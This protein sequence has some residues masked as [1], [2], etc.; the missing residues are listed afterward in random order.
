MTEGKREQGVAVVVWW[1][2]L[3]TTRLQDVSRGQERDL[4]ERRGTQVVE[5]PRIRSPSNTSSVRLASPH[6]QSD[7]RP[8][9]RGN[10][11]THRVMFCSISLFVNLGF[12]NHSGLNLAPGIV[13]SSR[14]LAAQ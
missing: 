5:A 4:T 1:S 8:T 10:A 14:S 12:L 6:S 9:F 7:R 2:V 13:V 11:L 3:C